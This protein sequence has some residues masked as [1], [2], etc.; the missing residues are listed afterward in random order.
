MGDKN[1]FL[2]NKGEIH[3]SKE[4]FQTRLHFHN[5][6][7]DKDVFF[8][9]KDNDKDDTCLAHVFGSILVSSIRMKVFDSI[10]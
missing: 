9:N 10:W 8:H 4:V 5:K 7:N 2:R 1:G 3:F 6:V